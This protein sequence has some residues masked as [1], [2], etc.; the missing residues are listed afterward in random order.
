MSQLI[1]LAT[2]KRTEECKLE[3]P[4]YAPLN[5]N[6]CSVHPHTLH[7]SCAE[8][9]WLMDARLMHICSL[10]FSYILFFG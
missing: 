9:S 10:L 7:Q 5:Y 4:Q 8:H 2:S 1:P 6:N 3:Q